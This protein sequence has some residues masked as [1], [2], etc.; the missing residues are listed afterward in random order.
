MTTNI[1]LKVSIR[2][3][4]VAFVNEPL[5]YFVAKFDSFTN[6]INLAGYREK[7]MCGWSGVG[8]DLRHVRTT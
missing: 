4:S 1:V 2:H 8:S 3:R 6:W 5:S 7:C